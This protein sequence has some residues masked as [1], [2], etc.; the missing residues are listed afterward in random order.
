M[1]PVIEQQAL[2]TFRDMDADAKEDAVS[3]VVANAMCAYRR[4]HERGELQRAFASALTRYAIR[5]FFDGRRTGTSQCSRD[6]YSARAKKTAGYEI[7]SL[8]APSDQV[9]EWLECLIDDN[10][11]PVPDQV[12]FLMDFPRWL[13]SQTPRNRRIAERL[14]LG[15]STSEVANEFRTSPSRVSQ[16]RRE[17]SES[18]DRFTGT[19]SGRARGNLDNSE[20]VS[21]SSPVV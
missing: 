17:L 3:E 8:G 12:V 6:V 1:M 21:T 2:T 5:Q 18:W 19:A 11:E 20:T 9:G 13:V 15:C 14:A 16:L 7:F 4:L 10:G